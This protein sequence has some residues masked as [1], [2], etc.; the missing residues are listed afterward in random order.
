MT[1]KLLKKI[2]GAVGYKLFDKNYVENSRLVNQY[3]SLSINEILKFLFEKKEITSL[4]QIGAN[5]GGSFDEL[6]L[7]IKKYQINSILVE[8][9][10]EHFQ[11]L[12]N[13]YSSLN[14][15]ILEKVAISDDDKK[16]Y[17]Y[18]VKKEV[19]QIY[20]SHAKA[21]SSF[22][23]NHLT[24]HGI[25]KKHIEKVAISTSSIRKLIEKHKLDKV[26]LFFCDAEGYDGQIILSFLNC[27]VNCKIIV[28]EFIHIENKTLKT[29]V[30]NLE[31]ENFRL[32]PVNE[33][34]VCIKKNIE[35]ILKN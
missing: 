21:I 20:G 2:I 29:V 33:N 17:L 26:D 13:L 7:F 4:M 9:I 10:D 23:L 22:D 15:V 31:K 12:E 19:R 3:S 6:S 16:K 18:S 25:K 34:L 32:F 28:F 8:P 5:D 30:K 27:S 11:N 14:N 24:K 35:I 1:S